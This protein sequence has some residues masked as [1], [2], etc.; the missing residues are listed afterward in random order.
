MTTTA[1]GAHVSEPPDVLENLAT[2]VV[3]DCELT[4]TARQGGHLCVWQLAQ[5]C[6][7]MDVMLRKEAIEQVVMRD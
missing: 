4:E 1:V 6:R 3:L 7:R 2:Q 5:L